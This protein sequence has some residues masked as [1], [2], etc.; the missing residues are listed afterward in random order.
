[1]KICRRK[2]DHE[3]LRPCKIV[4]EKK[5]NKTKKQHT[6]QNTITYY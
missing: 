5:Q 2:G 3:G 6:T 1:M 4:L